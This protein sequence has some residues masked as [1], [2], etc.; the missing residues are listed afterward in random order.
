MKNSS[1]I[2]ILIAVILGAFYL[3]NLILKYYGDWLWFDNMQYGSVFNTMIITK[4]ISFALFF[5]IFALFFSLHIRIAQKRGAKTRGIQFFPDDDP[6][7]VILGIYKGKA[8]FWMW[9]ALTL[10]LSIR[11]GLYAVNHWI[12]FLQFIHASSFGIQEPIFGKDTG[13]YIF[14]LPSLPIHYPLVPFPGGSDYS[15]Q[16]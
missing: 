15:L 3:V 7:Q 1:K 10:F 2:I 12:S 14:K 16:L 9:A 4:A 8:V 5:L 11:M 6:R 13:F